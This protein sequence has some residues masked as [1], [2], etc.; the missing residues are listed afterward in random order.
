MNCEIRPQA[1]RKE[2]LHNLCL[3]RRQRLTR[4]AAPQTRTTRFGFMTTCVR[5]PRHSKP[6]LSICLL[7]R[8][9]EYPVPWPAN[10]DVG[11]VLHGEYLCVSWIAWWPSPHA[12]TCC[13]PKLCRKRLST[14]QSVLNRSHARNHNHD[15][16][17]LRKVMIS[18]QRPKPTNCSLT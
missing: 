14:S 9:S 18:H 12:A 3:S 4:I 7:R 13:P 5:L 2:G 8:E 1:T 17:M 15:R 10:N 11:L 16:K 6:T